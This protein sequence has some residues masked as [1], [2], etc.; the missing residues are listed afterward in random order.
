MCSKNIT[1]GASDVLELVS[2]LDAGTAAPL[3]VGRR[4]GAT[5]AAS[6]GVGGGGSLGTS[7]ATEA[8]VRPSRWAGNHLYHWRR[9]L[10]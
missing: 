6:A 8:V 2:L 4:P 10:C 3:A 9:P 5:G 1:F 7:A